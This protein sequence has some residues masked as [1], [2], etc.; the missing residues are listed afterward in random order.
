V[1]LV[2]RAVSMSIGTGLPRDGLEWAKRVAGAVRTG[3]DSGHRVV[4]ERHGT[5]RLPRGFDPSGLR[6]GTRLLGPYPKVFHM[7]FLR[8]PSRSDSQG[9]G[10][11]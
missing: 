11:T 2:F 6:D 3:Q 5:P 7:S 8:G 9:L 4:G 1:A 10:G